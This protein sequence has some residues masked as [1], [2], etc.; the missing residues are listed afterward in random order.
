MNKPI[1]DKYIA[2]P[3]AITVFKQDQITFKSF[4]IGNLYQDKLDAAIDKLKED[5][6]FMKKELISRHHL[7]VKCLDQCRYT[8]NGKIIEYSPGG[9]KMLTSD[10]MRDYLYGENATNFEVKDRV[11]SEFVASKQSSHSYNKE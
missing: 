5:F 8:V 4:K 2:M 3:M 1:I 11:W 10:I 9:L 7:D 6:Y